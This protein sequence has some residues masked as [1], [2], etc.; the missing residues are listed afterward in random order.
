MT[1][2]HISNKEGQLSRIDALLA[3]GADIEAKDEQ[4]PASVPNI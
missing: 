1:I 4:V 3:K 2:L